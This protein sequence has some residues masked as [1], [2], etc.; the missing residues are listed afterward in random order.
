MKNQN[1][2]VAWHPVFRHFHLIILVAY[3][4]AL[5]IFGEET[6]KPI[7]QME[8]LIGKGIVFYAFVV[9]YASIATF[10]IS[11]S[12]NTPPLK[13]PSILKIYW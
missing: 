4:G 11:L 1:K 9:T 10:C 7:T 12:A 2:R 5:A 8:T 3:I 6:L 13:A